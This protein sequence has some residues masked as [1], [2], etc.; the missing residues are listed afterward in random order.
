MNA[1]ETTAPNGEPWDSVLQ[2]RR[3]RIAE[4]RLEIEGL[5][6]KL[7]AARA[8]LSVL[9]VEAQEAEAKVRAAWSNHPML[10]VLS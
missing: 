10:E 4:R 3:G 6:R 2:V 7:A 8:D 1:P 5:E 9:D